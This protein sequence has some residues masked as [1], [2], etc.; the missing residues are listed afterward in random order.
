M[1]YISGF[2]PNLAIVKRNDKLGRYFLLLFHEGP[3]A[4]GLV[5]ELLSISL[6][7]GK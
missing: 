4:S 2:C 6:V 3:W 5:D 7:P 1:K